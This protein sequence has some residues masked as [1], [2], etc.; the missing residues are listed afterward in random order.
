MAEEPDED[1]EEG[2]KKRT[3]LIIMIGIAAGLTLVA[4]GGG[5]VLGGLLS[6][7]FLTEERKQEIAKEEQA[8]SAVVGGHS[9]GSGATDDPVPH[10]STEENGIY[11]LEPI[12][13]NLSYP[14]ENWIRVEIALMF[15]GPP[16]VNLAED[17][18]QDIIA[19]LRTVSLQQIQGPRGFEYLK[20]D[21]QERVELRS[22][23]KVPKIMFRTF[24]IE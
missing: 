6:N 2:G 5:W 11:M 1:E 15:S 20:E 7:A 24:V 9:G 10:I 22:Q 18:H 12:T 4:A 3:G 13:S 14:S 19:Y 16:D 17:I 23:G 8:A 21:L